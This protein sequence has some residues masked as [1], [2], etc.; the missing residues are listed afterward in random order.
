MNTK[1]SHTQPVGSVI[2]QLLNQL[3]ITNRV[4]EQRVLAEFPDIMGEKFCQ[5]AIA[6]KI[7]HGVLFLEAV[8]S[9]WR[10]ELFFQKQMIRE[11]LNKALG[12]EI[13]REII[14]R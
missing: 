10:Q 2:D 9:V 12:E 5:R 7:E 1:K 6:V 11:R 4:R 3:G 13:V 8:N 14:F